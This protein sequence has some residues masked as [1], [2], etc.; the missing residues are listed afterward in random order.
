MVILLLLCLLLSFAPLF[1]SSLFHSYFAPLFLYHYYFAHEVDVDVKFIGMRAQ[2][3]ELSLVKNI[4]SFAK[5]AVTDS[6][7]LVLWQHI[8]FMCCHPMVMMHCI[9]FVVGFSNVQP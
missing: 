4:L 8:R 2:P 9:H 1:H 7:G 6:N 3:W 5:Q